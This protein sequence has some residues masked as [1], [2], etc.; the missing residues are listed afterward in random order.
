[1]LLASIVLASLPF[2]EVEIDFIADVQ[3]SVVAEVQD[4]GAVS[5][6]AYN[7][8]I[9]SGQLQDIGNRRFIAGS[10]PLQFSVLAER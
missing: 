6:V 7:N 2:V 10:K 3:P 8:P 4:N 1:M 9:E 5:V